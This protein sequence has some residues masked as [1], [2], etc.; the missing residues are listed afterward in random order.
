MKL[1][2][3]VRQRIVILDGAMGTMLQR[4]GL[5]EEDYRGQ[6]FLD[7][8]GSL[9][10][11]SELI[12]LSRPEV[13]KGIYLD[14]LRAGADVI[15]TNTF[16]A[17]RISQ[18]D[19][20]CQDLVHEMNVEAA[21]LA[22][23]AVAEHGAGW[24]AGAI[25]PTTKSA[26][27]SSNVNDPGHRDVTFD[28]V[29]EAYLEQARGLIEGGVD[30]ILIET[31]FDTLNS[32]AA[33]YALD[34]AFSEFGR[35]LPVMISVTITDR[36]G[37]T[38]SGQTVEAFWA[39]VS[40]ARPLS[41]GINCALG[42][43]DM[44][45]YVAELSKLAD[46]FFSCYPN[47]G[48]PNALGEYD[49][50][51]E[52]MAGLLAEFADNGWLNLVG[53]CCG[54][55]P[56]HIQAIAAAMKGKK[57]RALGEPP[58]LFRVSGLEAYSI[59]P[60]TGFT[61]V[62]ERTNVTGSPK[63]MKAVK[64]NDLEAGLTIARQQVEAGANLIDINLDEGMLDSEALM[65]QFLNLVASEPDIAR[66]PVMID[67]SRWA[68][69]QAGIKCLQ[70][71]AVVNSIS[72]KD[73][74]Q[75]FLTRARWL[76]RFG[77]AVVVMA[78]DE[79]GQAD[80][81]ERKVEICT[82][83]YRL[84][85]DEVGYPPEDIIFD[86]NVL[87][88]ATGIEEHN[89]YGLAFIE[90]V[91]EIKRTLPG[92]RTIGG[93]SNVSFSFRG[94]NVVREAMHAA[95]LYHAIEAG[96]DF[97]IVNAGMLTVYEEIPDQLR[98]AVEDV[99]L[100]R[101]PD[102]CER[103]VDL[104]ESFKGEG[105]KRVARTAEW[106]SEPVAER[107]RHALVHGIVDHVDEDVEEARQAFERPLQVIEGPLMDGMNVVGELFGEGKM[108]LPQVVKSARVMKKAVAYLLPYMEAEKAESKAQAKILMATV[109]GD[110][111]DIGK[112]IVGVVLACNGY[113]VIDLGVMVP[114]EK[115]LATAREKKVDVIGLSGLITPS[116]DEMVQVA[117]EMERLEFETPL[118]IGGATTSR[119]HTAVKI[120]PEYSHTAVHVRDASRAVGVVQ[121]LL[122]A[123]SANYQKE[124][125]KQHQAQRQR[126]EQKA[127][128]QPLVEFE[129]ARQ[130]PF[131]TDWSEHQ[132]ERPAF[133]G[134]QTVSPGLSELAELIDW[135]PFFHAWELKGVYP[136]ILS[137]PRAKE[138]FRDAETLLARI[139]D[140]QLLKPRGVYAFYPANSQGDDI[141]IYSD[142]SRQVPAAV[143]PALRQQGQR[144]NGNPYLSLADFVGPV[145]V[146][147]FV[148]AF[149]VTMGEGLDPVVRQFE[150]DHD[151][152]NAIMARALSDRLAEAFAEYLHRQARRDWG[153]GADEQLSAEDLIR[154]RY[155]GIRPAP[156]YPA[157]P[158]HCWK[159]ILWDLL[160]AEKTT[161]IRLTESL[162]MWPASSVSGLYF[163]HPQARYFSVGRVGKDQVE[164]YACRSGRPLAE[165]ERWLAP[166]LAYA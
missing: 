20:D 143:L 35:R 108:F 111:H 87:T 125:E 65:V 15:E 31:I 153:Y 4:R 5:E 149:A 86:P 105:G 155:R 150:Q 101:R 79:E 11:N 38:L 100:D 37:R 18:S 33:L 118:L 113:Q 123:D 115:I 138:L 119:I 112:N 130:R 48:L 55:G 139:V 74:R 3:L 29:S 140:E 50:G 156:G 120:S 53:G 84:L 28:E 137:E 52:E 12:T 72:L 146:D 23:E 82:R 40:H 75:E 77:A 57:P 107:L 51:P 152:Y 132:P 14:Y 27:L 54:T 49:Q 106:R 151:D 96:L 60:T 13:L 24:V 131:N 102:A 90:A 95:F 162:A 122:G 128:R 121:K 10:G 71:K 42:A 16:S 64:G 17:N 39:S 116:L 145:G 30:A 97:G 47:A 99:I 92:A 44:R 32:K 67:S 8:P 26:S 164:D 66:V 78:F 110:V 41:V 73:G 46:C 144:R 36:S 93:I 109:K 117:K 1:E 2:E 34:E 70:G 63:F 166:I 76:R 68:V 88:V 89:S 163:S 135:T 98:E 56:E 81:T 160:E 126:Y 83:S 142:E 69:L 158:D 124:I 141:L 114:A 133:L 45:P 154:E 129:K 62:G 7:R 85:V 25:G 159:L 43:E 165:V 80:T 161:G 103:L 59:Q 134:R 19:Y 91:R 157:C 61:M 58:R 147:D 94:N 9:K 127:E 6:R 136:Q 104:A 148:G 22:R 21:R